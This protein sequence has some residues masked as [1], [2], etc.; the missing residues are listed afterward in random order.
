MLS[1]AV[2]APTDNVFHA[3]KWCRA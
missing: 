3:D 1:T 2:T